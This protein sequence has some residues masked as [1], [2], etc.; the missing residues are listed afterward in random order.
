MLREEGKGRN[1]SKRHAVCLK[2]PLFIRKAVA[3]SEGLPCRLPRSSH[4]LR[5]EHMALPLGAEKS[6]PNS[7]DLCI[8]PNW[9]PLRRGGECTLEK[10]L[11]G[12]ATSLSLSLREFPQTVIFLKIIF[13]TFIYFWLCWVFVAMQAFPYLRQVQASL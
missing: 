1:T 6:A 12:C 10:E 3:F 5:L 8:K 11:G 4:Q 7:T 13:Y 9:G 2:L